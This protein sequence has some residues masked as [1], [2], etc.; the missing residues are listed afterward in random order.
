MTIRRAS[1]LD[2]VVA[3]FDD[4]AGFGEIEAGGEPGSGGTTQ[5]YWFHCTAIADGSR[6]VEPGHPVTFRVV[7]GHQ[8][9][10]EAT[11]VG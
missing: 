8:G 11:E 5:R 7:P 3:E 2:G 1:R 10:W 6:H 4:H 9:R